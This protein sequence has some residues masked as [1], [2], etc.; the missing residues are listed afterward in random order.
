MHISS[1][2]FSG[3]VSM[4]DNGVC[5]YVCVCDESKNSRRELLLVQ[6]DL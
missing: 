1:L 4:A 3:H 6:A 2:L 5:V